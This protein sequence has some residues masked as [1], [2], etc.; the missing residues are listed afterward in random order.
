MQVHF[1]P[2]DLVETC[3]PQVSSEGLV[4]GSSGLVDFPMNYQAELGLLKCPDSCF[5]F[6][7][8]FSAPS[9]K[10]NSS[11]NMP[12]GYFE[13]CEEM[14]LFEVALYLILIWYYNCIFSESLHK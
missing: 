7:L 4:E 1:R 10:T 2:E 6:L 3:S 9:S 5:L 13:V 12:G 14:K 8:S 11:I